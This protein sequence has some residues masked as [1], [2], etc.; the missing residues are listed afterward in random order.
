MKK[1]LLTSLLAAGMLAS[2]GG[3]PEPSPTWATGISLSESEIV[4]RVG[5]TK[6]V[7]YTVEPANYSHGTVNLNGGTNTYGDHVFDYAVSGNK[8]TITAK[9]VGTAWLN[10]EIAGEKQVFTASTK[11]TVRK[12]IV[13]P[14]AVTIAN[15]LKVEY[16]AAYTPVNVA[17]ELSPVNAE[18]TCLKPMCKYTGSEAMFS[19]LLSPA[20]KELVITPMDHLDKVGILEFYCLKNPEEPNVYS[21][22]DLICTISINFV[23]KK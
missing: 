5:E 7:E 8:V 9:E 15:P 17:F 16:E 14:T 21:E 13:Y 6:T 20:T 4:L 10:A 3:N 11:V 23:A 22:T 2:C 18:V 12:N 19:V 1:L